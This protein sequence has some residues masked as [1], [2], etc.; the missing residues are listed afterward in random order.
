[1]TKLRSLRLLVALVLLGGTSAASAAERPRLA[2]Y[3]LQANGASSEL[4]KAATGVAAHEL[5]S[6]GAFEVMTSDAVS[7]VL[8]LERQK[9]LLGC[10]DDQSD[11]LVELAGALGVD[12]LVS[13]VLTRV[14][15]GAEGPTF[16]LELTLIDAR[17]ARREASVIER[18][19]SETEL[20]ARVPAAVT[21]LVEGL[22]TATPGTLVLSATE[23]NA[24]VTIDGTVVGTTPMQ[25]QLPLR[26]GAHLVAVEKD[27]FIAWRRTVRLAPGEVK[28][29]AVTLVPSP[30][31]IARYEARARRFRIGAWI[32]TGVAVAGVGAAAYFQLH[33]DQLYGPADRPG[34]FLFHRA[35]VT[36][37]V[38]APTDRDDWQKASDLRARIQRDETFSWVTGGVAAA[39]GVTA[40]T[41]F[42]LGD[43]PGR[44]ERFKAIEVGAAPSPGGAMLRVGGT[45]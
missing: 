30:D 3:D 10:A 5:Q 14:D 20:L 28:E 43:D 17:G 23:P 13:G 26:P 37:G 16:V 1:M 2:V 7:S 4:A 25:G 6:L 24:T 15:G 27:G 36:D 21:R 44:Y 38:D 32:A 19:G 39:A 29:E 8:S 34:T 35:Q 42:L 22:V 45:F 41:L 11:C 12:H 18:A 9:Q 40:A 33:A 31:F